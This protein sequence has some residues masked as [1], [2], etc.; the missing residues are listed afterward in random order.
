MDDAR[1]K[2]L[3]EE[4]LSQIAGAPTPELEDLE[5]RVAALEAAVRELR[6]S[7]GDAPAIAIA[8]AHAHTPPSLRVL[9]IPGGSDRCVLEPDKPC[10]R[11]GQCRALGH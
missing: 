1:I 6:S 8:V 5:T 10:V 4:V 9:S 2:Q 11:S 3:A 7:P